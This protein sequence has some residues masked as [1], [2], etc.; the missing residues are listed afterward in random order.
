MSPVRRRHNPFALPAVHPCAAVCVLSFVILAACH[1]ERADDTPAISF[2]R[3]PQSDPGG[4]ETNDI[5]EGFVTGGRTGQ[6]IVLY[7]KSGDRW[8]LQPL[9]SHPFTRIQTNSK[10]TNATHLGR[11]YAA[12]L[13][14][15]DYRPAPVISSVPQRGG[16]VAAV[17]VVPGGSKPPS[18]LIAFSGYEWRVRTAPSGRGGMNPYDS[19]NAWTDPAGAMHLRIAKSGAEWTCAEVSLT[20][21]LG[22]GTYE[23]VIRDTEHLEPAAT[24]DM[25]TWDYASG[26]ENNR[27]MNIQ[28][29]RWGE[30]VGKNG[31]YNLEH[32]YVPK[33]VV[34][35][36]AP[37]GTLTHSLRWEDGRVSFRTVR[38]GGRNSPGPPVAEHVFTSGV[39]A[40]GIESVRMALYYFRNSR[41]PLRNGAE[42][43]IERF[44]WYP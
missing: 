22:Y 29:G 12:L 30:I 4:K 26:E 43:V 38:G 39:P 16:N 41:T 8:W 7:A 17:A 20:R 18:P 35:F 11:Q 9:V 13:V 32:Y 33:N 25:F 6:Q 2:T 10:W 3:I 24:L 5:I 1:P 44:A 14:E 23:F 34:K 40:P 15:P 19:S 36:T 28:M 42:V 21:S 37:S 27:E 31:Q